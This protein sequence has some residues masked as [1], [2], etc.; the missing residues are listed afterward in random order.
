MD[1]VSIGV[2]L[3]MI[4]KHFDMKTPKEEKETVR[5]ATQADIDRMLKI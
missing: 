1:M 4:E 3:D 2:V 5:M